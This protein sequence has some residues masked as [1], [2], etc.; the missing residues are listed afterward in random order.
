MVDDFCH[1]NDRFIKNNGLAPKR[2]K[3]II[4]QLFCKLR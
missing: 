4:E 2:D 1:A 3:P